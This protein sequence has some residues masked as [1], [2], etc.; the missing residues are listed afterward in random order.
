VGPPSPP[1]KST[2]REGGGGTAR[3]LAGTTRRRGGRWRGRRPGPRPTRGA[4]SGAL[5]AP[6]RPPART[7]AEPPTERPQSGRD[8]EWRGSPR[9]RSAL[10]GAAGR[11]GH[12]RAPAVH[13][14]RRR[15]AAG[16]LRPV[17]RLPT[18]R[19][20]PRGAGRPAKR[21]RPSAP[22]SA[23]RRRGARAL[24]YHR[25]SSAPGG[26]AVASPARASSG[27]ATP[28]KG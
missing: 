27:L 9:S 1:R 22:C 5:G 6:T 17:S 28:S 2:C 18:C 11:T 10:D 24:G 20:P 19:P 21:S 23:A 15:G 12:R 16:S 26:R 4:C 7:A 13:S 8:N 25:C 3:P 14:P